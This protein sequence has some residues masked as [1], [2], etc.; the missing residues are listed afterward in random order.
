M[1][2]VLRLT[3]LA[4]LGGM[5]LLFTMIILLLFSPFLSFV[6]I[7]FGFFVMIVVLW[8]SVYVAMVIGA[9]VVAFFHPMEVKRHGSYKL[10]QTKEE[11]RRQK[12]AS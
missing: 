8:G 7:G 5:S 6:A 3:A 10:K 2:P 12:G 9:A 11:G 1:F 4:V